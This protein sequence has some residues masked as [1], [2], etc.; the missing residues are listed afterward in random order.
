[1]ELV[2]LRR[3]VV[4]RAFCLPACLIAE[5]P[6]G[7]PPTQRFSGSDKRNWSEGSG[8]GFEASPLSCIS[9]HLG[10]WPLDLHDKQIWFGEAML[11]SALPP[12]SLVI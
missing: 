2:L 10:M 12:V 7:R 3:S 11:V 5:R 1:V 4:G 8:G 9:R 6:E